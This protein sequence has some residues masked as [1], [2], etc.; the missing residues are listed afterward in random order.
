MQ[1]TFPV[2]QIGAG[3]TFNTTGQ[4]AGIYDFEYQIPQNGSCFDDVAIISIELTT[5]VTAGPDVTAPM[6]F[7][8]GSEINL[9]SLLDPTASAGG[10]FV[11]LA[12]G[13]VITGTQWFA[14][15]TNGPNV[16][17]E[18]TVGGGGNCT[19]DMAILNL[20]I[21]PVA[22]YNIDTPVT[23]P[24]CSFACMDWTITSSGLG[25]FTTNLSLSSTGGASFA[26]VLNYNPPS[27]VIT[28]CNDGANLSFNNDTLYLGGTTD[29]WTVEFDGISSPDC[30]LAQLVSQSF[31]T[32]LSASSMYTDDL[33][34]VILLL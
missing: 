15:L 12:D 34:A 18:Y 11:N 4:S 13:T 30:D 28:I 22:P 31:T 21:T 6:T 26:Q 19:A 5:D 32:G 2:L 27:Y 33:L 8:E 10:T 23:D 3:N 9:F 25:P 14:D 29:T 1:L 17:F 24:L 16:S 20:T 7:C